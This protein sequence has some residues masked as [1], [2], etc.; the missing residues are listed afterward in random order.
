MFSERNSGY[1]DY[2]EFHMCMT[3]LGYNSITEKK[4]FKIFGKMHKYG[5]FH[6]TYEE[7]RDL[8]ADIVRQHGN[9]KK[10]WKKITGAKPRKRIKAH[11]LV[12]RVRKEDEYDS[13]NFEQ[14]KV[15][16]FM[17]RREKR[18]RGAI[19]DSRENKK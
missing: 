9:L 10:E 11:D 13:D 15:G 17:Q 5:K 14:A 16:A 2:I 7:F 8:W 4:A 6:V 19:K 1:L 3:A 18:I 12:I